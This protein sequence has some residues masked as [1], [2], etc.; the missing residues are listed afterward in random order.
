VPNLTGTSVLN[1]NALH[2]LSVGNVIVVR[3]FNQSVDGVYRVLSVPSATSVVVALD[4]TVATTGE[5]LAFFLQTQRVA[6]AS[7]VATLP[8]AT[9]LL[10]GAKVWVDNSVQGHWA[11]IEKQQPFSLVENV[12]LYEPQV[13][14]GF[15]S[16]IAQAHENQWA[17]VGAPGAYGTGAFYPYTQDDQGRYQPAP[18]VILDATNTEGYGN[19]VEIGNQLWA[20]AGASA[21]NANQGYVSIIYRP[22]V[23]VSF[24]QTQLFVAPDLD[25]GPTEFG[26]SVTMSND[27]HWAYVGAPGG[28]KVYA[29]GRVD[30]E[31]QSINFTTDGVTA[32]Y[33]IDGQIEFDSDEQLVVIL[34]NEVLV[35]GVDYNV[36]GDQVQL[37]TVPA[38]DL[39]L[40]VTRRT[41][42]TFVGD[43]STEL[44]PLAP[45]LYTATN[46]YSFTVRVNGVLQRPELD[47]DFNSDS[48]TLDLVLVFNTAPN[49]GASITVDADTYWQYIDTITVPG[50]A[51]NAQFGASVS[52][53]TDGR[54]VM[55]GAPTDS[56]NLSNP[57]TGSVYVFDR[58]VTRYLINNTD[59]VSYAIPVGFVEP[60]AVLLNNQYL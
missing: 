43:G 13:N 52:T 33:D 39:N 54:Q 60:V 15:G 45:Y 11:V 56:A 5:G 51:N 7:D 48:A 41:Q 55:I 59:T 31:A 29:Y 58:N 3:Y 28:N 50:L 23:S 40:Q 44:Y 57:R 6:Q 18:P 21:S 37:S 47:Y 1:F 17:L 36:G 27:E 19:S 4:I 2:N 38:P 24:D 8:Y 34:N 49:S 10:P 16:T 42:Q 9:D 53:T 14:S 25:F 26:Y 35:Y 30:V 12:E 20:I 46:I 22:P 32:V